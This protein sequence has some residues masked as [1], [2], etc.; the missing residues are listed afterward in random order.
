MVFSLSRSKAK[1]KSPHDPLHSAPKQI[2]S[3][4]S[5]LGCFNLC[6]VCSQG[7][8]IRATPRAVSDYLPSPNLINLPAALVNQLTTLIVANRLT[9]KRN[10]QFASPAGRS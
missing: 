3:N 5:S 10:L 2:R 6:R 8:F 9:L 7:R 1:S 4:Q